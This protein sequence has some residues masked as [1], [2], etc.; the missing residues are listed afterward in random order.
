MN[1]FAAIRQGAEVISS[2][3]VVGM[4]TE[5]VYGLAASVKNHNAVRRIFEIKER[6][7]FDPLIVHISS[8]SQLDGLCREIPQAAKVLAAAFWPGP[9]T[10]VLPKRETVDPLITAGLDTVAVRMPLHPVARRLVRAVGVPLAAP[11]ANKFGKTSPTTADHVRAEFSSDNLFVIDGGPCELGL[12]STVVEISTQ[13]GIACVLILRPG[14]VTEELI[15][16]CFKRQQV[17]A[18]VLY[19][20]SSASPGHL[21]NHYMPATPLVIVDESRTDIEA[22]TLSLLKEKAGICG[23]NSI[24]LVLPLEPIEAARALYGKLRELSCLGADMITVKRKPWQ[25]GETWV[26]IWDRLEKAAVLDLRSVK[27][28]KAAASREAPRQESSV[29]RQTEF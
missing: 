13:D 7:F 2:G 23:T 28:G 5:T 18:K 27:A 10:I 21:P 8:F 17:K 20:E 1:I 11:S 29:P 19:K 24:E 15:D 4:P 9:L 14:I 6:P 26:A 3:G 25:Y 16:D 12:E 22:D